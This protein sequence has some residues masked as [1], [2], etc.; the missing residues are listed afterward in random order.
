MGG[1]HRGINAGGG[2]C[3]A[4]GA[5]VGAVEA[6]GDGHQ[7]GGE[8]LD[9]QRPCCGVRAAPLPELALPARNLAPAIT[10]APWSVLIVVINGERPLRRMRN[11][12]ILWIE[13]RQAT[14]DTGVSGDGSG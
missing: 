5:D 14:S 8:P 10:G 13:G 7:P 9:G 6:M 4:D 3:V 12:Q 11:S 1:P 2:Q